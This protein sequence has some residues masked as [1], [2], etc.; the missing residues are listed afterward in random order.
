MNRALV[1]IIAAST[2][3]FP[4]IYDAFSSEPSPMTGRVMIVTTEDEQTFTSSHDWDAF[5]WCEDEV[6]D[7]CG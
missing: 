3:A 6:A 4:C 1:V 5:H 7:I 2:L